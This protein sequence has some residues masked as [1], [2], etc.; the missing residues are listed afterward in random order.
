MGLREKAV[1]FKP[2][3]L[4]GHF[5]TLKYALPDQ[6]GIARHRLKL[7]LNIIIAKI[8]LAIPFSHD[9]LIMKVFALLMTGFL[10]GVPGQK[11]ILCQKKS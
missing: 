1:I 3:R 5:S 2:F 8:P 10:A 6:L 9:S 4:K 7:L 11:S